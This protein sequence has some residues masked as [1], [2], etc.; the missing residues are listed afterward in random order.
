MKKKSGYKQT[1]IVLIL[2]VIVAGAVFFSENQSKEQ[3]ILS[4]V[5]QAKLDKIT[6]KQVISGNIYPMIMY[7]VG[8]E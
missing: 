5:I 4:Q 8:I 7:I 3:E 1:G 6:K 2:L